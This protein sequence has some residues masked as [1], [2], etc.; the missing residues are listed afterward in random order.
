LDKIRAERFTF[1]NRYTQKTI[2]A[3]A[4]ER[5]TPF[6]FEN[7]DLLYSFINRIKPGLVIISQGNTYESIDV[8]QFCLGSGIPYITVTQLV[9]EIFL[10]TYNNE[11]LASIQQVYLG[12]LKN[13]FV[14]KHNLEINNL[15]LGLTLTNT[16]LVF[17][18][19]KLI[20]GDITSF[21]GFDQGYKFGLVGRLDGWHKGLDLL[22]LLANQEKWRKRPVQFNLYGDGPHYEF[23]KANIT[24]LNLTNIFLKG[25]A[26]KIKDVWRENHFLLMPSRH[27][28]QALSLIEAM[29]CQRGAVVTKVGGA[30][31]L[32]EDGYNGFIADAPTLKSLDEA[33]ERAWQQKDRW[34]ELGVNAAK[35]LKEKHPS[36]EVEYFNNLIIKQLTMPVN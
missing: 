17:N 18:P 27:E 15:M 24:R 16:Q 19:C 21:P 26:K 13:Y 35:S 34:E 5:F 25:Y 31:E 23:C 4:I 3:R 32:I 12:A 2:I 36:N 20:E 6:K 22:V 28:G 9:G 29:Y 10:S 1:S 7:E 8:M 33:M 14:S 30:P 11:R